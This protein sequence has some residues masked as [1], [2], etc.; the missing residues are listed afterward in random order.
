[1]AA[2]ELGPEPEAGV[3]RA[4]AVC[5]F[6]IV[7]SAALIHFNKYLM[8]V[9][10]FPFAMAL[11]SLHMMTTSLLCGLL[12]LV[13]PSLFPSMERTAGRRM[14]LVRWFAP[15]GVLFATGLYCSNRAYLHCSVAFLQFMK[16]TNVVL[17][18]VLSCMVGLQQ[19]TRVKLLVLVWIIMGASIAVVGEVHFVW[20]GFAVQLISQ[21]GESGK[22]VLGEWIMRGSDLRLDPLTYTMFMAPACLVVLLTGTFITWQ[23]E[24]AVRFGEMW[25][26]LLPNAC[27]AFTLNVAVALVIKECSAVTFVLAGLVKD[28][29]IV[30][31]CVLLLGELVLYQQLMGF[32]ICLGGIF[33]WSYMRIHPGSALSRGLLSAVGDAPSKDEQ[34]PI[35]TGKPPQV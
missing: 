25:K 31:A 18:F 35:L 5:T 4:L 19:C 20:I 28:M 22:N 29:A 16:E 34:A 6:Y 2:E 8:H 13:R 12:Y 17:V 30:G 15:L 33:T 9:D 7:V 14:Q 23:G 26:I 24:V 11:T 3:L 1:M 27:L 10:R 21:F 32:A